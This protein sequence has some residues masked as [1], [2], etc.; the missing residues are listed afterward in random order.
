[1][2]LKGQNSIPEHLE[3]KHSK[4]YEFY[5]NKKRPFSLIKNVQSNSKIKFLNSPKKVNL[6][7]NSSL[8]SAV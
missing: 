5:S 6:G 8:G 4:S 2:K 1:M 3:A 7:L